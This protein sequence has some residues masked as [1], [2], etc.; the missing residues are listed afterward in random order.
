MKHLRL[1]AVALAALAMVS[2]T[3]C[4]AISEHS[5]LYQMKQAEKAAKARDLAEAE[6][7]NSMS[8]ELY[9]EDNSVAAYIKETEENRKAWEAK[10][11]GEAYY[12]LPWSAAPGA[13]RVDIGGKSYYCAPTETGDI[14]CE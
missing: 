11:P 14:H 5:Q 12:S 6:A 8:K 13:K 2:L 4:Q 3:G 10:H 9:G 1:F 7:F